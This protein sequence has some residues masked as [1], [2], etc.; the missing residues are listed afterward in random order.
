[1]HAE[2]W[3]RHLTRHTDKRYP[4]Y[5]KQTF[6]ITGMSCA[7]CQMHVE[8][9]VRAL[10]GVVQA[11]VNLLQNRLVITYN[12]TALTPAQ[13]IAA[14]EK[15][16][17]GAREFKQTE[18][19]TTL[20]PAAQLKHRFCYSLIL[21][22]PLMVVA[23]SHPAGL[24][25]LQVVLTL[26]ILWLNRVFFTRGFVQLF[27]RMPTMDSLVALGA[28]SA[29]GQSFWAWATHQHDGLYFE[30]AAMIVTLVTL[31]KWL[32]A[33]AKS[34]TTDAIS[35]LVKLLPV[36]VQIRRNGKELPVSIDQ[37]SQGD[38]LL[39]RAGQRIGADGIVVQG[40]GAVDEAVLTGESLPQDK[41]PGNLV[42]AGTLLVSG[43]LEV[44]VQKIGAHT[45]L[46]HMISL[47][48]HATNSKAPVARLADKASSVF[49]PVV[50]GIALVTF[51]VWFLSGA[52][53][54]FAL[55]CAVCVL[56]ISCPCALGLATPTAIMVGMGL[57]AKRGILIKS[58]EVLERAHA[59]HAVV[60]DKTGTV[61]TGQMQVAAVMPA[62][63]IT[64]EN[65]LTDAA[66]LEK[67]SAHPL[68]E[69]LVKKAF[70]RENFCVKQ[71]SNMQEFPGLGIRA[72]QGQALLS[73]GNLK[74]MR[75]WHIEVPAGDEIV[76]QAANQGQT[77]LFF[78]RDHQY[79]GASG[80]SDAI[81][82][83][84][85]QAV[86][87]LKQLGCQVILLTGDNAKTAEYVA[88]QTGI[89]TVK[90]GVLP[91]Q[92]QEYLK[93]L[94]ARGKIVAMVGDGINDAPSLA[95]ADVAIALGSGTEVAASSA[96]IVLMRPDLREVATA[97]QLSR[98]TLRNIKENL[99]WAFF[100]NVICIPLAAGVFY[101][102]W[103]WKLHPMMAAAAMSVSSVCVVLNALRLNRFK[104]SFKDVARGNNMHK[105]LEIKGMMCGHCAGH[106]SRALNSIPG[107]K[108]TVDL[109]SKTATVESASPVEDTV[110]MEAV[111]N[112]G[113]EVTAIR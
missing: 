10:P 87:L 91:A 102:L 4:I 3:V 107:V 11:D 53:F 85:K 71:V 98:A 24:T 113:Y 48:E 66:S 62:P 22:I 104:P 46:A 74:A 97:L 33:R 78:A 7:A 83:T 47:V 29:L 111:K 2:K 39:I 40:T 70:S 109:A 56:V 79:L 19:D 103:G 6:T 92:K 15:A 31:G 43:Y 94:Q 55:S 25:W 5:M 60:L 26:P 93:S 41:Q 34:K 37:I 77:V 49:V 9:A 112:A 17:Y 84:S 12:Q 42:S 36:Q 23:M 68:A 64:E 27:K 69:S 86:S 59:T 35:G 45:L 106:V 99:F 13:I 105:V 110:L 89:D 96:G 51:L 67:L 58:A 82:P 63:G 81:K 72:N 28:A 38:T 16:G 1:M 76:E 61:T 50:L 52:G 80:L 108:A 30:S 18:Q 73:G 8:R 101:P 65:L 95:C 54:M 75:A 57:A 100:Y 20:D 88:Q 14:V 44:N 32:E 90:A 21:L